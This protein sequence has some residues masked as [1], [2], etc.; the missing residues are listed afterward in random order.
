M[1]FD[2]FSLP[3]ERR[4][5]LEQIYF[6]QYVDKRGPDECWNWTAYKIASGYGRFCKR[7]GKEKYSWQAHHAAWIFKYN[8]PIPQGL[9]CCHSCDNTSCVNPAHIFI[10]TQKHNVRD[11]INKGRFQRTKKKAQNV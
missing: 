1:A 8:A 7:F 10:G 5:V 4:D 3:K 6:N 9:I 2:L 11:S